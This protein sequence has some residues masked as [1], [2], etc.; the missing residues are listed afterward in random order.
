MKACGVIR[1]KIIELEEAPG[2]PEGQR[3]AVEIE[4]MEGDPVLVAADRVRQRFLQREEDSSAR[5]RLRS[6]RV[7]ECVVEIC[8]A[9]KQSFPYTWS[10]PGGR[11]C[12]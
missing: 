2:L 4:P 7:R 12:V 1:G 9:N 10:F 11:V 6:H 3:V 8:S 5:P